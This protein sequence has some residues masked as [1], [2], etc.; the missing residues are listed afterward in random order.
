MAEKKLFTGAT[1]ITP[2]EAV[3][4]GA[5]GTDGDR[6][7]YAGPADGAPSDGRETVDLGGGY[8]LPGFVDTHC[9]GG[10]G[11]DVTMGAYDAAKAEFAGGADDDAVVIADTHCRYGTTA[12][13]LATV[14]APMDD[15][16]ATLSRIADAAEGGATLGRVL[17]SHVEGTFLKDPNYAGAQAP[18]NF[19]EPSVSLFEEMQAAARGTI[20]VVNVVP[21]YGE[22]SVELI[23]HIT[24]KYDTVAPGAGH[25]GCDR[26]QA[27]AAIDAGLRLAIHFSNGPISSSYKPPGMF[28]ET[29]LGDG[30]VTAELIV[31][32][33]HINPGYALSFIAAKRWNC[34]GV[35]DAMMTVSAPE[36]ESF[37]MFGKGAQVDPSGEVIRLAGS[38]TLLFG[39]CL[40]M[41]RGLRNVTQWLEENRAG[42][43]HPDGILPAA[44]SRTEA[45]CFSAPM[46][47]SRPADVL[48]VGE[49]M[50][51]L[52]AGR[53]ADMVHLD[54]GL[55]VKA[56]FVGAEKVHGA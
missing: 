47:T 53:L 13:T 37:E 51:S 39:S 33:H 10:G 9:H 30:R 42:V 21:E 52:V 19:R 2:D 32:G 46:F 14:A 23:R 12:I 36:I 4:K 48:G 38:D 27:L 43:Y 31:D 17:G 3:E 55:V 25:T 11:R 15:I 35:T 41:D 5:V 45:L 28:T 44:P 29:V 54:G 26:E 6:I 40:T 8:I 16:K 7:D 56:V 18:R 20:R 1:L 50:G 49:Q 34:T 24:T 22:S